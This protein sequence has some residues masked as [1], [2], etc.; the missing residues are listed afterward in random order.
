MKARYWSL[1]IVLILVN[2]LI[3]ATLFTE[4]VDPRFGSGFATRTPV[5]T[6]TPAPAQAP[7]IVIPTLTPLPVAPTPTPTR[8]IPGDNASSAPADSSQAAVESP[9]AAVQPELVAPGTV[10]IRSGPGT[11]FAV[12]GSLAANTPMRITGRNADTSWWQVEI[13]SGSTGWV[14]SSVVS[15]SNADNVFPVESPAGPVAAAPAAAPQPAAVNSPPPAE[16]AKPKYQY[17]PTGWY[18]DGNAGLTRFLGTIKDSGGNPV[19]GVFVRASCGDYSTISYPSGPVGWGQYNES[20][21]WPAGFY[22]ITVD[23]KPVPCLWVLSIVETDDRKT[24]KNVLSE[25]IP[26]EITTKKSII[27]ANWRKNW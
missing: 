18:D 5:P 22:D 12:I 27:T 14:A 21:D 26:V 3:F 17:E 4:L 24:V 2:Y 8:V 25:E 16:P 6:F 10:N 9:V 19:N 1:A 13:T 23:T 7:V 20:A 15:A 11:N